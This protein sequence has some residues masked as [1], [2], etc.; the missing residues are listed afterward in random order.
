MICSK[1][2]LDA[3]ILTFVHWHLKMLVSDLEIITDVCLTYFLTLKH[4]EIHT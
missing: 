1:V 4:D 2:V 3:C